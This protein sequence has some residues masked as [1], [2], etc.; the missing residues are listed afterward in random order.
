MKIYSHGIL[1][2]YTKICTNE[3][4][5]LYSILHSVSGCSSVFNTCYKY[6]CNLFCS[7]SDSNNV[8]VRTVY[9]SA[10]LSSHNF[11]AFKY[12]FGIN[13]NCDNS[14]VKALHGVP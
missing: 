8:L 11:I 9:L 10:C 14:D 7:A 6:F 4:F 13:Y 3:N 5:P 12:Q 1:D 2:N